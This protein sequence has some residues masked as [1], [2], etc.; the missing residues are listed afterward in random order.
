MQVP[1]Y[2]LLLG[3]PNK[4]NHESALCWMHDVVDRV[5]VESSN[6][7]PLYFSLTLWQLHASLVKHLRLQLHHIGVSAGESFFYRYHDHVLHC[8]IA[9]LLDESFLVFLSH[10]VRVRVGFPGLHVFPSLPR[11]HALDVAAVLGVSQRLSQ[12]V[13]IPARFERPMFLSHSDHE[14]SLLCL[15]GLQLIVLGPALL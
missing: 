13:V 5:P 10:V 3:L 8:R 2:F 4:G 9:A 11:G 1:G 7:R 14:H 15:I 6:Q 12:H